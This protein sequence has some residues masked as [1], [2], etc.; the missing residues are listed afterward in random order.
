MEVVSTTA[1]GL[2]TVV[3]VVVDAAAPGM[4]G[5]VT[6]AGVVT[7]WTPRTVQLLKCV[8]SA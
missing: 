5:G 7:A 1:V 3:L 4:A 2:V 8:T 6:T